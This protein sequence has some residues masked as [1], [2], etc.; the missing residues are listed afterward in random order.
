MKNKKSS[1][2][3][4]WQVYDVK[5]IYRLLLKSTLMIIM[6]PSTITIMGP[7]ICWTLIL[8]WVPCLAHAISFDTYNDY[9]STI[10]NP[11]YT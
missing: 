3:G 10:F 1:F 11:F 9:I 4:L 5:C 6:S 2:S 7:H 8:C